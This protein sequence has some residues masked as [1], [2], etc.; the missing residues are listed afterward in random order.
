MSSLFMNLLTVAAETTETEN[1]STY[2][3]IMNPEVNKVFFA[4]GLVIIGILFMIYAAKKTQALGDLFNPDFSVDFGPE[5]KYVEELARR[6]RIEMMHEARKTLNEAGNE[7]MQEFKQREAHFKNPKAPTKD[8][9]KRIRKHR[10]TIER[11]AKKKR[12]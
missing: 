10:S 11:K 9:L 4:I 2:D 8:E 1:Q 12:R 3:L 7:F 6:Q 5:E